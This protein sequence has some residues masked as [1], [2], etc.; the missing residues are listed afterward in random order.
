[1]PT[2]V[3]QAASTTPIITAFVGDLTVIVVTAVVA[4]IGLAAILVGLGYGWRKL[5]KKATGGKF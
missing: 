4:V 3:T 5:T 2:Y 1:M